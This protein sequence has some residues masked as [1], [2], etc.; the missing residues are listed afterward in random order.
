MAHPA[1]A[2]TMPHPASATAQHP[3]TVI[4]TA[5]H[6]ATVTTARRRPGTK[7]TPNAAARARA[8]APAAAWASARRA[9]ARLRDSA[10]TDLIGNPAALGR[11]SAHWGSICLDHW[12]ARAARREADVIVGSP[13]EPVT[14][15]E[16]SWPAPSWNARWHSARA[17]GPGSNIPFP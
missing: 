11:L 14:Y 9:K 12:P 10:S 6:R 8:S 1:T 2:T 16:R 5:R 13:G 3:A 4:I 15:A 17:V 7:T